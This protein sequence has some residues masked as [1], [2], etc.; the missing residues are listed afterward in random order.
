MQQII[1]EF[2]ATLG[3]WAIPLSLI[4]TV[5][6]NV[7]GVIPSIFVTGINIILWGPWWGFLISWLSEIMGSTIAFWLYGK[8]FRHWQKQRQ[9][10]WHWVQRLNSLSR[11]QQQLSLLVA[12]L[13][14]FF[15]SGVVNI[16]GAFTT[17]RMVDFIWTTAIGKIPS[18]ALEVITFLGFQQLTRTLQW[19]I[20]GIV[21]ILICMW[22][23][24]KKRTPKPST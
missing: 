8:G 17:V 14:P 10:N 16:V 22:W 3:L 21:M 13:T 15:P 9:S 1:L 19:V 20:L 7:L 2:F 23:V 24:Q 6:L 11:G 5:T 4:F 12:R 18:I